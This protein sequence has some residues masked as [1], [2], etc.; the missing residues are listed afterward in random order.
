MALT[1]DLRRVVAFV[2]ITT[3]LA[4]GCGLGARTACACTADRF[5]GAESIDVPVG[6]SEPSWWID[7]VVE[8]SASSNEAPPGSTEII[9]VTVPSDTLF[10][11]GS[12]EMT[13]DAEAALSRIYDSLNSD[14][15]LSATLD[16]HAD[17]TGDAASNQ[18]LSDDREATYSAWIATHWGIPADQIAGRGYG[19]TMPVASNETPTG[20]AQNRRCGA[21]LAVERPT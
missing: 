7:P 21:S 20:R 17:A 4:A 5:R 18:I 16:C 14:T 11:V 1:P 9:H 3:T 15:I 12:S 10:E 2:T 13:S 8:E 6:P 19:E